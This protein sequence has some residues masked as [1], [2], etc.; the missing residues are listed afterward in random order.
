M[1]FEDRA[2]LAPTSMCADRG[3]GRTA[4]TDRTDGECR[5]AGP[6]GRWFGSGRQRRHVVHIDRD[7]DRQPRQSDRV[8]LRSLRGS[9]STG[10]R[11][12]G[13]GQRCAGHDGGRQRR[14][15]LRGDPVRS[16]EGQ[17]G[18]QRR[19]ASKSTAS[20]PTRRSATSRASWDGPPATRAASPGDRA[21]SPGRSSTRCAVSRAT[22]G[23]R[24]RSTT[25]WWA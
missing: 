16:A 9:R 7:R 17:A 6:A 5:R 10:G 23:R 19:M 12:G 21:R 22:R 13:G 25:G 4:G 20:A 11:R 2:P 15:R 3:P 14:P 8:H 24:S 18:Q 1:I